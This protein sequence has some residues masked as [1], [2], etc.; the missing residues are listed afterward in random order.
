MLSK[1]TWKK[2]A[3][4]SKLLQEL[5]AEVGETVVEDFYWIILL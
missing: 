1:V 5:P 3:V 4:C 2:P